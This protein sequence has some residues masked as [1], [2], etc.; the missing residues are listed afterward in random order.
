LV[1][2][3]SC[4]DRFDLRVTVERAAK[5]ELAEELGEV[6]YGL[7]RW[8]GLLV[9]N[10]TSVGRVHIGLIGL[11]DLRDLPDGET[12]DAV[13]DVTVVS[14]REL[15]ADANNLETWSAMLLPWLES[16]LKTSGNLGVP[17]AD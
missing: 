17:T 4:D 2:V 5:R 10:D 15:K 1:G 7:R 3:Q 8:I 11:W 13:G 12:E 14:L 9:D 6:T 16:E